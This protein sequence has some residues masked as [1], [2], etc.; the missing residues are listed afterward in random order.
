MKRWSV[1]FLFFVMVIPFQVF[2]FNNNEEI[3]TKVKFH[4]YFRMRGYYF[5]HLSLTSQ[6]GPKNAG[7]LQS[8]L[9]I[10]PEFSPVD[11]VRILAEID[12]LDDIIWG[13]QGLQVP[14]LGENPNFIGGIYPGEELSDTTIEGTSRIIGVKRVWAEIETPFGRLD[15]GRMPS[16][17]GLGIWE[18]DGRGFRNEWGD[19]HFGDTRDRIMFRMRP[20]ADIP[21]LIAVGYDKVSEMSYTDN[22]IES[23]KDDVDHWLL[24]PYW[25]DEERGIKGGVFMEAI[26]SS[27]SDTLIGVIDPYIEFTGIENVSLHAEGTFIFGETKLFNAI[28]DDLG[29][30]P[31]HDDN[32]NINAINAVFR[33]KY[34]WDPLEFLIEVG[35]ASGDPNGLQDNRLESFPMDRDYNVGLLMFERVGALFSRKVYEEK[36]LSWAGGKEYQDVLKEMVPSYGAVSNAIYV[37]VA[38]LRFA[39]VE[40]FRSTLGV[41]YARACYPPYIDWVR[42]ID[43]TNIRGGDIDGKNYGWELDWNLHLQLNDSFVFDLQ[44]GWFWPGDAFEDADGNARGSFALETHI[45]TLF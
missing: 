13:A 36:T 7:Y 45:T 2:S 44:L 16:H 28:R 29:V 19:A 39:P 3:K 38:P 20:F 10:E 35:Y 22:Y 37:F 30:A 9:R 25:K 8:R 12:A 14:V 15:V 21:F 34:R 24:I 6:E 40:T 1:Y 27:E 23:P 18:N 42:G 31:S 43:N 11:S 41:L 5:K 32:I 17:W 33:G 4:G 26:V